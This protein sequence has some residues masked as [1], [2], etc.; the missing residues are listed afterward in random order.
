MSAAP[1]PNVRS[2]ED[3]KKRNRSGVRI[4]VDILWHS[5]CPKDRQ[6]DM[7]HDDQQNEATN[8]SKRLAP[9][10]ATVLLVADSETAHG[11]ACAAA[12]QEAGYD[13]VDVAY[14]DSAA[15]SP[16]LIIVQLLDQ[17]HD[18]LSLCRKLRT[19]LATR[20]VPVIVVTKVDD[21]HTREQIVRSGATSIL[22]EPVRRTLLLRQVRRLLVRARSRQRTAS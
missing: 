8:L 15:P 17:S 22:V 6:P 18:G 2:S 4:G 11:A 5:G 7:S 21:A 9:A 14:T 19:D 16:S 3:K 12:L 13:V 1:P 20:D 10:R